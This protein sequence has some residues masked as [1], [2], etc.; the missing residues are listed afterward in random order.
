ML[1]KNPYRQLGND[2]WLRFPGLPAGDGRD[3]SFG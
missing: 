1:L 3:N 2:K